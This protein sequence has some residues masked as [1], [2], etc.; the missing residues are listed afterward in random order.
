MFRLMVSIGVH[1]PVTQYTL[2]LRL[3]EMAL[4]NCKLC[5]EKGALYF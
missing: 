3:I 2:L 5:E 1:L 4:Y